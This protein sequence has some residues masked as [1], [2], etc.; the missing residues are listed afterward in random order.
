MSATALTPVR[1]PAPPR[2]VAVDIGG[3]SLR[4]VIEGERGALPLVVCE[5]G[6]FGGAA[7]FAEVQA[8]L[9]G[10]MR[11]LAYDRAGLGY[12]DPGP[13]PRDSRAITNDLKALL[14]ALG[15]AAPYILVG[16]SMAAVHLH[17]F[18]LRWPELV[19]GVVLLDAVPPAALVRPDAV[20]FVRGAG[21]VAALARTGAV[22][23]L[24]ALTAPLAGN[25]I[26]V[27]GL[28]HK[29]KLYYFAS[30]PHN[31]W[32]SKELSH[33]LENGEVARDLGDYDRELPVAV[34]TAGRS[35]AFWKRLQAEPARRSRS[36]YVENVVGAGHASLLGPK[37][38]QA[39]VRAVDFVL[40]AALARGARV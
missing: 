17:V 23:R 12:S 36:G 29:E 15:E 28:A 34:V 8:A 16:H 35:A 37:Y 33:W 18:T 4:V 25:A 10:Q 24:S 30:P 2:G 1:Q 27:K 32:A 22:L 20:R 21:Q 7:D 5:A 38:C 11:V 19:K 39:V 31:H 26:G 3:R 14:E 40:K 9:A 6:A 13:E